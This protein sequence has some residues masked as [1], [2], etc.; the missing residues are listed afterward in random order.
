M[1]NHTNF[2]Y[3]CKGFFFQILKRGQMYLIGSRQRESPVWF[4]ETHSTKDVAVK[5]EDELRSKCFFSHGDSK[6]AE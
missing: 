6:S 5:W 1:N 2:V 3:E 4:Q